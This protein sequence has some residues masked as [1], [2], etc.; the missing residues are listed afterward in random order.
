MNDDQREAVIANAKYLQQVRPIDPD[1]IAEYVEGHPHPATVRQVL[2]EEA[3]DLGFV[4]HA[5]GTFEPAPTGP[6]DVAF[7]GV[8]AFPSTYGQVLEEALVAAYGAGWPDGSS[9]DDLRAAI[10][11]MKARYLDGGGGDVDYGVETALGYAIYHLPATYASAKY[12]LADLARDGLLPSRLRVLDVGAGVGGPALALTDLLPADALLDYH[13][14]E[15]SAAA[16]LLGTLLAETGRNFHPSVHR[17]PAEAHEPD[18]P[19]DLILC[20]NVLSELADPVDVLGTCLDA[21]A[22]DGTLAAIAPADRATATGL[23]EIERRVEAEHDATIYAPTVRLWPGRRP[24]SDS[25]SFDVKPDL[26][27]PP[28]QRKL[29]EGARGDGEPTDPDGQRHPG[30]GEFVNVDVQYAYSLLRLDGQRRVDFAADPAQEAPMADMDDHVTDRID[31]VGIKLSHD[32]STDPAANPLYLV[33]DGSQ[34]VDH[35]AVR[36]DPSLLNEDLA[37]ADYGDLLRFENV[38]VLWNDDEAAYNLVV[39]SETVVDRIGG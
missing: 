20:S 32:L 29:D 34:Q 7:E 4:E 21:L 27:V 30:D 22:A 24:E 9:G 17:E 36:T 10:R 1:E 19:Y 26:A 6:V 35:V 18:G 2:R 31:C 25:W 38:L 15:P 39:G 8:E 13:A 5:D 11:A 14:V 12:V 33:G 23:R 16:D 37:S 3:V 28:F